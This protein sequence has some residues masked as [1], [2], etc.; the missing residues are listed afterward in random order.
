MKTL[1]CPRCGEAGNISEI[2]VVPGY[3]RIQGLDDSGRIVWEGE[4][5]IDWDQQRPKHRPAKFICED[6]GAVLS[7]KRLG[8]TL[9][10]DRRK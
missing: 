4:T 2:D 5:E 9:D 10:S 1:K 3:A 6:C 7:A 8:I